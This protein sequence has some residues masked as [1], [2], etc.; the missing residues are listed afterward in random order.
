MTFKEESGPIQEADSHLELS[1]AGI[2]YNSSN[3]DK[4]K[5]FNFKEPDQ[6]APSTKLKRIGFTKMKARTEEL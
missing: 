3:E 5:P 1:V 6:T 4:F 2:S